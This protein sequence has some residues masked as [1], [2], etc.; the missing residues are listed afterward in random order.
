L[1]DMSTA[2]LIAI[3][4]DRHWLATATADELDALADALDRHAE[5][6]TRH[7]DEIARYLA[8]RAAAKDRP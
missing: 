8:S 2:E 3:A 7:A 5:A 1:S 6:H 4:E